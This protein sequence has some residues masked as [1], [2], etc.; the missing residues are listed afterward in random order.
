MDVLVLLSLLLNVV[1]L[2]PVTGGVVMGASWV[3]PA[4]G[5]PTAARGILL[6]VYL[7]ILIASVALL[8]RPEAPMVF[9]LLSVQIIYKIISPMTVGTLRNPVVAS[10]LAIAAFHAVTCMALLSNGLG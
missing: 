2:V 5:P 3:E 9:A 7:A 10:N 1:V 6:A 4:Y 8:A